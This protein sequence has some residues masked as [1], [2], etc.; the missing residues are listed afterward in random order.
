MSTYLSNTVPVSTV[1]GP[2]TN[3]IDSL[4][5]GVKWGGGV[6]TPISLTYSFPD[7]FFS[8]YRFYWSPDYDSYCYSEPRS[9]RARQLSSTEQ[10]AATAALSSWSAV[11]NIN[12]TLVPD[13]ESTVGDIRFAWTDNGPN[14]QAWAYFPNASPVGGDVWL[15]STAYWGDGFGKGSYGY[16]TLIHELGHA[17]G[18]SHP[19]EG[20]ADGDILPSNEDSTRYT[21]MSYSALAGSTNSFVDFNPTTPMLYDIDAIQY[22]YGANTTYNNGNNIYSFVSGQ[23]YYQTIWDTG[24]TDTIEWISASESA[25]ID[26]RPGAWSD[27]GKPLTFWDA[28]QSHIVGTSNNTVAIH[29]DVVIENAKGGSGNDILIGN[30]VANRLEGNAGED[31]LN[32]GQGNDTLD[33]GAGIDTLI[34]GSGDDTYLIDNVGDVVTELLN[35]GTDLVKVGIATTGT[36]TLGA[37]LENA[38]L[39][40]AV[41]YHLTGNELDN[42]LTGNAL[43]NTLLGKAGDDTLN[44][45]AGTDTLIGGLGND[46]YVIDVLADRLIEASGEGSD[47]VNV[48]LASGTYALGANLENAT[49]TSSA[50]MAVNL[51]GNELANILTGNAAANILDGGL[52][53][54]ALI[55]GA[56]NDTYHIN[57]LADTITEL[58]NE[59]T[60]LVRVGIATVGG[61]YTLTSNLENATLINVVD[62]NLTGNALANTLTG[63]AADNILDGG[64]GNDT[65]IGGLGNDTYMMDVLTDTITEAAGEGTDLV[66]VALTAAGT[67]TLGAN[68]ENATVT[69]AAAITVNLTGNA[70]ANTLTGNAA[71]NILNGSTGADT[72]IG[73]LGNDTYIIDVLTDTIIEAV[74]QG[75]DLV[76]VALA[77]AGTY[78][79]GANLENATVTSGASINVN[80][81]GNELA[82]IL[83]GN[84][85]ANILDGGAGNDTLIGGAGNDTYIVSTGDSVVEALNGGIDLVQSDVSHTLAANV[86]NLTLTGSAD[87]SATGNTLANI[88]TGNSGNNALDGGDGIDTLKGGA[89]NDTYKVDLTTSNLLQDTVTEN[90]NEG[91]DTIILRGGNTTLTTTTTLTLG[92]NLENLDASGTSTAKLNLT[93][94]ALA[95]TLTGNAADNIL[96]GGLGSDALIGG[97]GNDCYIF[98]RGCGSDT[99]QENDATLGNTDVTLFSAGV[100][101]NQIWMRHVGNDLEVSIIGTSDKLTFDD[102]YLGSQYHAEQFK[103]A[104]NRILLD[105]QVENLVQ[106]MAAFSP[107]ASG[108]TTLP[109]NYQSAL[110]PIIAA[111]WQ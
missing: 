105:T 82:N 91:T 15:K 108:Q 97:L 110:S 43:A 111:N 2:G 90:V 46:T 13:N 68:I 33:G 107:P 38:T 99:V 11:A 21:I 104:D 109:L 19:F 22:L 62:Y 9:Y 20:S 31:S 26:L 49:V 72:L 10:S 45:G 23:R 100:S 89:G 69:S 47:L 40:N 70:L 53:A 103:T 18:L 74:G 78:T 61:T 32:G 12:F 34:G 101:T 59:G 4:I 55:G 30:D 95:N 36:Y 16:A 71:D 64:L 51:T 1:T 57:T 106:A 39:T 24:G 79:L 87:L 27:L 96:D 29:Y 94:N 48:A 54:D 56:G 80:L 37:N 93:G 63:N 85:A 35:E 66:N 84:A 7:G 41:T 14:A 98:G 50:T 73:G 8:P 6:A 58:A 44:G 81:T 60:D 42:A 77:T 3:S 17:L 92:A 102:W 28:T 88:L 25:T 86:E 83:T 76:N 75:T 67:Y 65:L 5:G 52:G